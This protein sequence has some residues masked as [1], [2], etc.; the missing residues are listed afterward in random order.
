MSEERFGERLMRSIAEVV[1]AV[2][3]REFYRGLYEYR[4]DSQSGNTVDLRPV[5]ASLGLPN[6]LP[7]V[8]FRSGAPGAKGEL[9]GGTTVLVGFVNSDPGRPFVAFV[10]GPD[11]SGFVPLTAALDAQQELVLGESCSGDVKVAKAQAYV[12]RSGDKLQITGIPCNAGG[13]VNF[14]GPAF[15]DPSVIATPGAPPTGRSQVKA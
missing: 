4:V 8:A 14:T 15:L 3:P 7:K 6:P 13:T 5:D 1:R 9:Q 12:L 11:G 10:E 2:F